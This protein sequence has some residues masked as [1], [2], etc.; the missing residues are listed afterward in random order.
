L[1]NVDDG[2]V[3]VKTLV[4]DAVEP[5]VRGQF[6]GLECAFTVRLPKLDDDGLNGAVLV[7]GADPNA[8]ARTEGGWPADFLAWLTL[9][10][11]L[12]VSDRLS[13]RSVSGD[14][15]KEFERAATVPGSPT[16]RNRNRNWHHYSC[17]V[18]RSFGDAGTT[19]L[20][21][22]DVVLPALPILTLRDLPLTRPSSAN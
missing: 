7:A 5:A 22:F 10:H 20:V 9:L 4:T 14:A 19:E 16:A 8:Y 21:S 18:A 13:G 1:V 15:C 11:Y 2:L 3:V 6:R 17:L 12:N